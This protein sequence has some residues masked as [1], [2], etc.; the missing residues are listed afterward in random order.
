MSEFDLIVVDDAVARD[1]QPFTLTRPAAELLFG[2]MR[3]RER[4]ER[5]AGTAAAAIL[6][7]PHLEGFEEDDTPPVIAGAETLTRPT[8]FVLSRFVPKSAFPRSDAPRTFTAGSLPVAWFVPAGGQPPDFTTTAGEA[9]AIEGNVLNHMWELMSKNGE[10]TTADIEALIRENGTSPLPAGTFGIGETKLHLGRNVTVEPGVVFDFTSGPVSLD[11]DVTVRAFARIAGPSWFG[12]GTIV[13]GGAHNGVCAGPQ[14]RLRGEIEATVILGYSNKAHDG[15]IGHGYIGRWVNLGA[16]TTN[17]DLKNNYGH[18]RLWT[19]GDP[20]ANTGEMKI[21]GFFGDHVKTG[22]G[23]LINT[24][25]VVG[26]GSNLFGGGMPPKYVPPFSWG[27]GDKL[28]VYE[29]DKF[30]A[31]AQ[32][33]MLRRNVELSEGMRKVLERAWHVSRSTNQT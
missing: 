30:I 4:I 29:F 21:G 28:D 1:W 23:A 6:S 26:A 19:P 7:S 10:Q 22:I 18:V 16:M 33:V 24:G 20:D 27:S 8:L 13:L 25:C 5:S 12:R 11:D 14:C 2:T 9:I 31:T 32:T 15:F 17:S 3:L